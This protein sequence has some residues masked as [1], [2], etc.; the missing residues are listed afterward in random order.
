MISAFLI[1]QSIFTVFGQV[2]IICSQYAAIKSIYIHKSREL[3]RKHKILPSGA[4]YA[5]RIEIFSSAI[6]FLFLLVQ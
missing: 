4:F 5:K 2:K 1:L 6:D 3:M